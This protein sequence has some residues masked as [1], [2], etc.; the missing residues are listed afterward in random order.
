MNRK[1]DS[2]NQIFIELNTQIY[3]HTDIPARVTKS[4]K[5]LS[6]TWNIILSLSKYANYRNP[7]NDT[8]DSTNYDNMMI[9]RG[10]DNQPLLDLVAIGTI[11]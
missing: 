7:Q 2:D 4:C 3:V 1:L 10:N 11:L 5:V 6:F 9:E 8:R